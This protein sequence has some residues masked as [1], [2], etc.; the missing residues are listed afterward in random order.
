MSTPEIGRRGAV[1]RRVIADTTKLSSP[2]QSTLSRAPVAATPTPTRTIET[3]Q[4][5]QLPQGNRARSQQCQRWSRTLRPHSLLSRWRGVRTRRRTDHK[6]QRSV[7]NDQTRNSSSVS[8]SCWMRTTPQGRRFRG[9]PKATASASIWEAS[10]ALMGADAARL[11]QQCLRYASPLEANSRVPVFELIADLEL[12]G[13]LCPSQARQ[14][15]R[16]GNTV[17]VPAGTRLRGI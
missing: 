6:R 11:V 3:A 15:H 10:G 8:P 4:F 16:V 17:A 2:T 9:G 12:L 14:T 13:R 7:E 1:A 5:P